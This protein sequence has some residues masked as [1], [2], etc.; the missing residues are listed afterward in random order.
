[1]VRIRYISSVF[2][3]VF[4]AQF[5]FDT[6]LPLSQIGIGPTSKSNVHAGTVGWE[7]ILDQYEYI[8]QLI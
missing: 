6:G 8:C 4:T 1:M 2:S 3:F 7:F 5:R